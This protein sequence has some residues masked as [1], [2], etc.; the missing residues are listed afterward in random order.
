MNL[1][2]HRR[3]QAC[4]RQETTASRRQA[5]AG[6]EGFGSTWWDSAKWIGLQSQTV[7]RKRTEVRRCKAVVSRV[8]LTNSASVTAYGC[9]GIAKRAVRVSN[10]IREEV[11]FVWLLAR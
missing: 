10:A 8:A 4:L 9:R 6:D 11:R 1:R 5:A 3:W 2:R 7:A